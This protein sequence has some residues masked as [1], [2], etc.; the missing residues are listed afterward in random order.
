MQ[1]HTGKSKIAFSEKNKSQKWK[2]T[3]LQGVVHD[4]K[5]ILSVPFALPG[6]KLVYLNFENHNLTLKS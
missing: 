4:L 1:K 3:D 2:E 5:K 6:K